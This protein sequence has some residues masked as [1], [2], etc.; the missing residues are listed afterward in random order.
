MGNT[1]YYVIK[2][3]QNRNI[4]KQKRKSHTSFG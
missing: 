2:I 3:N 1:D 4:D